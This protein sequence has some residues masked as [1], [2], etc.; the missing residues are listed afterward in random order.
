MVGSIM[1]TLT[2]IHRAYKDDV[3]KKVSSDLKKSLRV[4][5]LNNK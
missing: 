3:Y 1:L 5:N 2:N 4:I